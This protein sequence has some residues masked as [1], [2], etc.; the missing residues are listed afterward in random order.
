MTLK[1]LLKLEHLDKEEIGYIL[2]HIKKEDELDLTIERIK[3]FRSLPPE[4]RTAEI[5]AYSRTEEGKL[6]LVKAPTAGYYMYLCYS[7]G[8]CDR[9]WVKVNK[10]KN[11]KLP[12]IKLKS[13]EEA[14]TLLKNFDDV[15]IYDFKDDWFLWKEYFSDPKRLYPPFDVV[16][17]TNTK[18]E[19]LITVYK[20]SNLISSDVVSEERQSFIVPVFKDEKYIIIVYDLESGEQIDK[21][22]TNFSKDKGE[23]LI[24]LKKYR[25][26]KIATK[27]RIVE[28]VKEMFSPGFEGFDNEYYS[29]LKT[30]LKAVGENYVD[31]RRKG[32]RLEYLFFELLNLLKNEG[33]IDEVFWYGNIAKYGICEP[34]PGGKEGNPDIVFGI[35]DYSFVLELTTIRGIR[36]QWNSAEASS[37]PDHIAKFRKLNPDKKVIGI[38]SAPSIH[39]QLEQNLK[40]NAKKEN[41]GMIFKPSIEFAEFLSNTDRNKLKEKLIEESES[42]ISS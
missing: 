31:N 28:Q 4:K 8:L 40:L 15:E 37:V 17:K 11:S 36:A 14:E 32:G 16:I 7:T 21:E 27:K 23:F 19:I 38:F 26:K 9:T 18:E 41:V 42:Q 29:K 35:D 22:I 2:F 10:S 13:K 6:T 24:N 12:A 1:L 34:A 3:N 20:D 30:I 5:E 25:R 39:H 33:V